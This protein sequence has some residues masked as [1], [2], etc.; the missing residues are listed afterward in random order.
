MADI[1]VGAG[2]RG[3]IA[4]D[5]GHVDIHAGGIWQAFVKGLLE[6]ERAGAVHR[7][8]AVVS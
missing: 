7:L 2:W 4:D 5:L 3:A 1:V 8:R 6:R